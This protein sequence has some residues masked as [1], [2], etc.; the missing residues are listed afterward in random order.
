M[1]E[2][3]RGKNYTEQEKDCLFECIKPYKNIIQW[4]MTDKK[5]NERKA[6]AWREISR[7][8]NARNAVHRDTKSLVGLY[9]HMKMMARKGHLGIKVGFLL[10]M[11]GKIC[12][13]IFI[14]F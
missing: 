11:S 10:Y 4:P 12:Q 1:S 6:A 14:F 2:K 9:K 5:S 13:L 8:Y 3:V 7:A